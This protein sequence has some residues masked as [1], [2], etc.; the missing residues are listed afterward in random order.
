MKLTDFLQDEHT[1]KAIETASVICFKGETYP[2]LFCRQVMVYC[3][4]M[5]SRD[6][7]PSS[8]NS[9]DIASTMASLQ[10]TFLGN[11]SWYWLGSD[12]GL[13]KKNAAAWQTY[14]TTYTGPNK[15][16][17]FTS[18]PMKATKSRVVVQLPATVDYKLFLTLS[19]ITGETQSAFA[20][21]IYKFHKEIPSEIAV[22]LTQYGS[23]IGRNGKQFVEQW[24]NELI[25]PETSLFSLSQ[26]LF[27]KQE[28][29]F[30]SQWK[31][32]GHTYSAPF[33]IA[34]WSEQMWQ[35]YAYVRLN[36]EGKGLEAKK[37]AY[38][39]PF[40]FKNSEWQSHSLQNLQQAHHQLYEL[41]FHLKNGGSD[42]ALELFFTK[43]MQGGH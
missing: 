6:I 41:D 31:Q 34:F 10:S 33:W 38:R 32:V 36:N 19:T 21:Q 18:K 37:V 35:A 12:E 9:K 5:G 23:L 39:L 29:S 14:L 4:R 20:D 15:L 42:V 28:R 16:F 13:S 30:F 11:E 22:L 17:L 3:A 40:S 27:A 1:Q 8:M 24:L 7:V 26:A 25:V 43:F 2:F